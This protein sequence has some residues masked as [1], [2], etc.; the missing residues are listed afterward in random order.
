MRE[1]IVRS[2]TSGDQLNRDCLV[3]EVMQQSD[4]VTTVTR[5][6]TYHVES[7]VTVPSLNDSIRWARTLDPRSPRQVYV[8]KDL[9]PETGRERVTYKVLGHF[10]I[11]L[12]REIFCVGYR[13]I[14]SMA[15]DTAETLCDS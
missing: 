10:Y 7:R 1:I 3:V 2:L 13:H 14:L 12:D 4:Y 11:V 15:V 6:C 9:D 5:R 8:S